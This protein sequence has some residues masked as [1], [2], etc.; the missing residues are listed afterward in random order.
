M[1]S[2]KEQYGYKGLEVKGITIHNTNSP[3]SAREIFDILENSDNNGGCHFLIDEK[4]TIQVLPLDWCAYH[5]GKGKDWGNNYT[6]AIEIC[7]SQSSLETY[8]KAQERAVRK[9]KNLMKSYNLI[10]QN[11]YFH[12]DFAPRTYCPHK[13]LD[14]YQTKNNFI[15][16]VKL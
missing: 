1:I 10:S 4:E 5:T 16:E 13:I 12:N 15:K 8:M 2:K 11:I 3:L 6:I 7:R 9:I 14:I